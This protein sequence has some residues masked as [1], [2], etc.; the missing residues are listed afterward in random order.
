M[1]NIDFRFSLDLRYSGQ[2][3]ELTVPVCIEDLRDRG[4]DLLEREFNQAHLRRYGH[5][6]AKEKI[7]IA[8]VRISVTNHRE[9]ISFHDRT[10]KES[11]QTQSRILSRIFHDGNFIDCSYVNRDSLSSDFSSEGPLIIEEDT[12]TTFVPPGFRVAVGKFND[13]F[14]EEVT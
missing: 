12:S 5:Y 2:Q 3:Y 14:I 6:S 10:K 8:N 13:L 7:E 11:S 1:D 4:M 9:R